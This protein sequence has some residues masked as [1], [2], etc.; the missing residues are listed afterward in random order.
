MKIETLETQRL[1]LK[2]ASINDAQ[3]FYNLYLQQ[4]N[5]NS[6][7]VTFENFYISFYNKIMNQSNIVW[8]I[9][10]K[11]TNEIIGD[12]SLENIKLK[13]QTAKIG[14]QILPSYQN[15]GFATE[16]LN[17]FLDYLESQN[18]H[19]LEIVILQGNIA[20][21]KVAKKC[22]FKLESIKKQARIVNEKYCDLFVYVK[23]F[24]FVHYQRQ[25]P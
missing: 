11:D 7:Q 16:S 2:P 14:Y 19:R 4:E 25:E 12:I 21:T 6:N 3:V 5:L 15:N 24:N 20:S 10:L 17:C 13:H 8:T 9:A 18:F 22:G 1:I 23:I